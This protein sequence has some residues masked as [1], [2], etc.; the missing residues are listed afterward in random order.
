ME[1]YMI[2][3]VYPRWTL[4]SII[5]LHKWTLHSLDKKI[6]TNVVCQC[7]NNTMMTMLVGYLK[8]DFVHV[9][10]Y[11]QVLSERNVIYICIPVKQVLIKCVS[12]VC[13]V[14][15]VILYETEYHADFFSNYMGTS[16]NAELSTS[17]ILCTIA[18]VLWILWFPTL[19]LVDLKRQQAPT[20][21]QQL[22]MSA[23]SEDIE[24]SL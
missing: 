1:S 2:Q 11:S 6:L 21:R 5:V 4:N 13:I 12:G 7:E 24:Q 10:M 19:L 20:D 18:G 22:L 23:Q 9:I 14:T 15:G 8:V 3:T 16:Y 17:C